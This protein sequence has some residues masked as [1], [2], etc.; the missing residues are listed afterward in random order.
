[1]HGLRLMPRLVDAARRHPAFRRAL[2]GMYEDV[3]PEEIRDDLVAVI[4]DQSPAD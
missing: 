2:A 1:M 3:I 4:Q